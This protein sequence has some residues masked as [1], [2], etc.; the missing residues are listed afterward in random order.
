MAGL[1]HDAPVACTP[2]FW[3]LVLQ[4]EH[5]LVKVQKKLDKSK[6]ND[7][8]QT[9]LSHV[10]ALQSQPLEAYGTEVLNFKQF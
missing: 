5:N 3:V 10:Y 1:Q 8:A 9:A 7:A 6:S 2:A 4:A